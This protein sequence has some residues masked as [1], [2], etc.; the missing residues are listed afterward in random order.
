MIV[1]AHRGLWRRKAEQN[2]V[3]SLCDA[4]DQGFG[5]ETDI[6]DDRGRLV[7][8]H[9]CPSGAE[10][11]LDEF[12]AC[13]RE[14]RSTHMLAL[15]VK[16][17]GLH[18]LVEEAL[19]RHG[20]PGESYFLF[21]MAPP[22]ALGYLARAMPCYTRQSEIESEPAFADRAAGIWLDCF[23]GDWI[24][25]EVIRS[26]AAAGRRVALVSPELHGREK[27]AAWAAWRRTVALFREQGRSDRL[28]ICT[29]LPAEAKAYFDAED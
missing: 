3:S 12:L 25:E 26:H 4:L 6:R 27:D 9:D 15:N 17:C 13:Y 2:T 11:E 5:I 19:M 22:D 16:A 14:R 1:L 7:I 28:M 29:D 10:P 21:D 23:F 8:S 20:I 24:D 18:G